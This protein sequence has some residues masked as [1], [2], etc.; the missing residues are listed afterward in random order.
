MII[1]EESNCKKPSPNAFKY[2][3]KELGCN[4]SEIVVIGNEYQKDLVPL[5]LQ[6]GSGI[7]VD[8]EEELNEAINLI[9]PII[10]YK[11]S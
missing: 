9:T 1:T 6:G 7:K 8:S 5:I 3:A 11:A 4:L 2:I 10:N